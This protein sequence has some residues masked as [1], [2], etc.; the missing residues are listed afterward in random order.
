MVQ[1]P[2]MELPDS[3]MRDL[4]AGPATGIDFYIVRGPQGFLAVLE[5]ATALPLYLTP[6]YYCLDDLLAGDPLPTMKLM[7]PHLVGLSARPN[8]TQAIAA[9]I[10][11]G[12]SPA[13]TGTAGAI[14]LVKTYTL[15]AKTTFYRYLSALPDARYSAGILSAKTYLTSKIDKAHA[16]TGFGAVGRYALPLP[17]PAIHVVEYRL[18]AGT[19]IEAGTAAPSFGQAGGGV[20]VCLTANTAATVGATT[21]LSDY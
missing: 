9:L 12:I 16:D 8:R 17:L 13:Y 15:G 3:N 11:A 5:D 4:H 7:S 1:K 20:E 10:A 2:L 18:P 21:T 14:P 6:D 19:V